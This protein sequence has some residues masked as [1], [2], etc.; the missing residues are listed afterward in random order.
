M[1]AQPLLAAPVDLAAVRTDVESILAAFVERKATPTATHQLPA[2][3]TEALRGLLF[4]GGKRLR[5]VLCVAGWYA[6]ARHGGDIAPLHKAAASLEMFHTFALI[7]D[8]VMDASATRRGRPAAHEALAA[9]HAGHPHAPRLGVNGAILLGDLALTWSD[10]LLHTAGLTTSQ[11]AAAQAVVDTMRTELML[12]QYLDLAASGRP[13]PDVE[14]ALRIARLK[15]G[16]YTVERPLHLGAALA[17]A[18]KDLLAVLSTF[19]VPLGEAF[20]LRDDLLGVFG[21]PAVTGKTVLDDLRDGKATALVALALTRADRAQQD[22]LRTLIGTADLD[23]DGAARVREVLNVTGARESVEKMIQ[24]RCTQSRQALA[25]SALP[26]H[27]TTALSQ[28]ADI[29]TVR[30]S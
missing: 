22:V 13:S 26:A 21:D 17:G 19:A 8:D 12:G 28:L 15:S 3:I 11:L 27:V 6:A 1:A 16:K 24:V 5:P 29:V 10:E 18:D 30:T 25:R 23:E 7:H 2:E 20:Q 9:H 4:A 14:G